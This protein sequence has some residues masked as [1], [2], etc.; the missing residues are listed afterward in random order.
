MKINK[1]IALRVTRTRSW[2]EQLKSIKENMPDVMGVSITAENLV[3]AYPCPPGSFIADWR[4]E[5]ARYGFKAV[6]YAQNI[7]KHQFRD[8]LIT[9]EE[10]I[11]RIH[12]DIDLAVAM[13]FQNIKIMHDLPMEAVERSIP[14]A[15]MKNIRM[16]DDIQRPGS[17]L[18]Q[19]GRKGLACANYLQ[20]IRRTGT[21]NFS[22]SFDLGLFHTGINDFTIIEALR[23]ANPDISKE[24]AEEYCKLAKEAFYRMGKGYE[25][26]DY[27]A[28]YFGSGVKNREMFYRN[29]GVRCV[30]MPGENVMGGD[31]QPEDLYYAAPYI[32]NLTPT[33]YHFYPLE[34][35]EGV[36]YE[37]AI[38]YERIVEVLDG[39]GYDGT[40]T[41]NTRGEG[42]DE[43]DDLKKFFGLLE[44][45]LSRPAVTVGAEQNNKRK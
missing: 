8:H 31:C 41:G 18:P 30:N 32:A 10:M 44:Y 35:A 25:F 2:K 7:D 14:Y 28:Q 36:W 45:Y 40:F 33:Y 37:P 27:C 34:G 11:E 17:I 39:I 21:N 38:D 22:M 42:P 26:E 13:G 5:L 29:F 6:T 12:I 9:V 15:E 16:V 43:Y 3:P 23:R 4:S 20:M 19:R 1:V 24:T